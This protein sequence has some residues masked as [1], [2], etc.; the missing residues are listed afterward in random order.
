MASNAQETQK[1]EN[2][3]LYVFKSYIENGK[4][5]TVT[6][7]ENAVYPDMPAKW[8]QVRVKRL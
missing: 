4:I 2:G 3:S 7:I 1:Q 5:P 8:R 6:A